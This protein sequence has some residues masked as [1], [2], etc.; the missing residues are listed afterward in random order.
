MQDETAAQVGRDAALA[1]IQKERD[2]EERRILEER[3]VVL[4]L[5]K[6]K[7][8]EVESLRE[9]LEGLERGSKRIR[10]DGGRSGNASVLGR[11]GDTITGG[12]P[13]TPPEEGHLY[14]SFVGEL[15]VG[16]Y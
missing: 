8:E 11:R 13:D 5:W 4:H 10:F 16:R 15:A 1:L 2:N 12:T 14:P 7:E 3:Q 6:E 9:E